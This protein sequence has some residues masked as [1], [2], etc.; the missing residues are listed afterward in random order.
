MMPS[1]L[2]I[3]KIYATA[4]ELGMDAELL[5]TYVFNL[6]GVKHISALTKYEAMNV[7]DSLEEK[8]G[9]V[10]KKPQKAANRISKEQVWKI[11]KL[12][13]ELGWTDNP[14]RLKGFIRKYAKV[15]VI[16]W[17]TPIQASNIIEGMKKLLEKDKNSH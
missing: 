1:S 6:V 13:E 8:K 9:N 15:D 3:K 17:L 11:Q 12:A 14:N 4:K 10:K 16:H 5:H 7:I 2:Q